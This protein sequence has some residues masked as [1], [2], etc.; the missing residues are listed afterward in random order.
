MKE[1]KIKIHWTFLILGILMI[2]F[3]RWKIFLCSLIAVILHE[4]GHSVIGR[5]LGYK[6]N[7]ITLMPYGASLSG[8]HSPFSD[9]D[10]IKIAI[11]GPL[12]NTFL[13]LLFVSIWWIFPN[14]YNF[15]NDFVL[16]NIY[17]L[18]FNLLPVYPL[19][20]GRIFKALLSKKMSKQKAHKVV[21]ILGFVVTSI[22]FLLFFISFFF[23]LNYMIGINA[24]FLLVGLFEDDSEIYYE[25]LTALEMF[26]Q[27]NRKA[28]VELSDQEP[29]FLA[30]KKIIESGANEI[31]VLNT[32][33]KYNISKNQLLNYLI[34]YPIDYKLETVKNLQ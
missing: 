9:N 28:K 19:D 16:A 8:S 12:V 3:G 13:I 2:I 23:K 24:I 34:K 27:S 11:A 33:K 32:E 25:K 30:Y 10:E 14:V 4:M 31:T 29:L 22:F 21:R 17:T 20:G 1:I 5:R 18:C 15:T 6:L 7:I 26:K